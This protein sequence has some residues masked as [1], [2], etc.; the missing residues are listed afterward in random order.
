MDDPAISRDEFHGVL[1]EL[2]VINRLL[3]GYANILRALSYAISQGL[4]SGS[5]TI[6]LID[7]GCGGGDTLRVVHDW[8]RSKHPGLYPKV[9]WIGADLSPHAIDYAETHRGNRPIEFIQRDALDPDWHWGEGH[10]M[11]INSLLT[12]HMTEGEIIS[13]LRW[14]EAKADIGWVINDLHRHPVAYY[15]IKGLTA[16]FSKS[17]LVRYDA[18]V[19]VLRAFRKADWQNMLQQAAITKASIQWQWAFRYVVSHWKT[20]RQA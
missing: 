3:G 15:A 10:R 20:N 9:R 1:R 16:L 12:H 19:S 6:I 17:R 14:Q 8:L 4:W 2:E 11:I 13:L 18:G 7:V 5:A